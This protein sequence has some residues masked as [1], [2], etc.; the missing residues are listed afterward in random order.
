MALRLQ[1]PDRLGSLLRS[2]SET[3]QGKTRW[4]WR[5]GLPPRWW[6]RACR[7]HGEGGANG[8]WLQKRGEAMLDTM[9]R[10]FEIQLLSRAIHSYLECFVQ[11]RHIQHHP[12]ILSRIRLER[13][14]QF[15]GFME[16]SQSTNRG[17]APTTELG[18]VLLPVTA[19]K[20]LSVLLDK[21]STNQ[22]HRTVTGIRIDPTQSTLFCFFCNVSSVLR[23]SA[24]KRAVAPKRGSLVPRLDR[25]DRWFR[26][27]DRWCVAQIGRPPQAFRP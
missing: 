2:A 16:L 24:P 23:R 14:D 6:I 5:S 3:T 7:A 25:A 12:A 22:H 18:S 4:R 19:S 26:R 8:F 10:A 20:Q 1:I 15:H 11:S 21:A 9:H 17:W 13:P 27:A